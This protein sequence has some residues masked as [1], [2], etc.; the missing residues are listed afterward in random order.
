MLSILATARSSNENSGSNSVVDDTGSRAWGGES[1]SAGRFNGVKSMSPVIP[2]IFRMVG[3]S[4]LNVPSNDA[5]SSPPP[6]P[7]ILLVLSRSPRGVETW[8][9]VKDI[10]GGDNKPKES[11]ISN[12]DETLIKK[13]I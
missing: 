7:F 6:I 3:V 2:F 4:L 13:G 9:G 11:L 1:I 12:D 8:E 10:C 5:I